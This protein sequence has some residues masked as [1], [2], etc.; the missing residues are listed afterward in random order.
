MALSMNGV[1]E[2]SSRKRYLQRQ[3]SKCVNECKNQASSSKRLSGSLKTQETRNKTGLHNTHVDP[4]DEWES[5]GWDTDFD[6]DEEVADQVVYNPTMSTFSLTTTGSETSEP[7]TITKLQD[8]SGNKTVISISL[9]NGVDYIRERKLI[10]V[11]SDVSGYSEPFSQVSDHEESSSSMSISDVNLEASSSSSSVSEEHAPTPSS[12]R[13][14]PR[15]PETPVSPKPFNSKSSLKNQNLKSVLSRGPPPYQRPPSEPPPPPLPFCDP[16]L[17][18]PLEDEVQED[19]EIPICGNNPPTIITVLGTHPGQVEAVVATSQSSITLLSPVPGVTED[20]EIQG[21]T[22]ETIEK[23]EEENY[24]VVVVEE[25]R[26]SGSSSS[27]ASSSS[28]RPPLPDKV[29]KYQ[30]IQISHNISDP[31]VDLDRPKLPRGKDSL[32]SSEEQS[33]TSVTGT[34]SGLLSSVLTNRSLRKTSRDQS[35][36][37]SGDSTSTTGSY[38]SRAATPEKTEFISSVQGPQLPVKTVTSVSFPKYNA[39]FFMEETG[40]NAAS[41]PLPPVPTVPQPYQDS[42]KDQDPLLLYPWYHDIERDK[43]EKLLQK[44]GGDGFYLVRPSRRAGQANPYTLTIL[45]TGRVFHLNLRE[46]QDGLYALGKEKTREKTFSTVAELIGFHQK[47]PIL[48]TTKGEPAGKTCLNTTLSK[49][50]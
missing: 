34:I 27:L 6:D 4:S 16:P 30:D 14:I 35:S 19:Y 28:D 21:D 1:I 13:K 49:S 31:H 26:W 41:R 42:R 12:K 23:G 22:Y 10:S 47:E 8:I 11:D 44:Q 2:W 48:L 38:S 15:P 24:E 36:S 18:S 25:N 29:K 39:Q 7:S 43:A 46:R 45:Y 50:Y 9:T 20:N 40:T 37:S 32:K 33:Q 5:D 17:L 3:L